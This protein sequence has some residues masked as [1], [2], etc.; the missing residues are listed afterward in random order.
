[1]FSKLGF[2]QFVMILYADC[3]SKVTVNYFTNKE[4]YIYCRLIYIKPQM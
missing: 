4:K 1:M 3:C 2:F